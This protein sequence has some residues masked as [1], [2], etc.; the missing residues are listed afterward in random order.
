MGA[1]VGVGEVRAHA[2]DLSVTASAE[3]TLGRVNAILAGLDVPQWLPVDGDAGATLRELIDGDSTGP[4]RT[5]YGG[6]R[7]RLT[8]VQFEAGDGGLV[9]HGGVPVKNV[10]GYDLTKLM[11]GGGGCF[12][13]LVTVTARTVRRPTRRLAATV[14]EPED[15]ADWVNALLTG[16]APPQWASLDSA[17]VRI[18]W[19]GTDEG[20]A[21]MR[22]AVERATAADVEE[23]LFADDERERAGRLAE[24]PV[25]LRVPPSRTAEVR[26]ALAGG[27]F[28]ADPVW[29]DVRGEVSLADEM[30]RIA[31]VVGGRVVVA[32]GGAGR[33][34]RPRSRTRRGGAPATQGG[35]RPRRPAARAARAARA[36]DG[37]ICR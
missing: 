8:G 24:L 11:V 3:A 36:A 25:R 21:A 17:G 2:A 22:P 7:D 1:L 26:A 18:G 35:L 27:R 15:L 33:R 16:D 37:R 12:G 23:G 14:A 19:L 10:A 29:G 30:R 31:G 9:T 6:W 32:G 28:A 5:G 4:L 20:A 34:S 13:R